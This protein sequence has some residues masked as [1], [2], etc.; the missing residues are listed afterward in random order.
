MATGLAIGGVLFFLASLFAVSVISRSYGWKK[1][2]IEGALEERRLLLPRLDVSG[3]IIPTTKTCTCGHSRN[4]HHPDESGKRGEGACDV[5][6]VFTNQFTGEEASRVK[7][8]C[9]F[10]DPDE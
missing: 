5:A 1:G 8:P 6:T 3:N 4:K 10:F 7:C 9:L 2:R